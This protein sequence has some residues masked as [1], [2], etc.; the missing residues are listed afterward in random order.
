MTRTALFFFVCKM[1]V[2]E[3]LTSEI[4]VTSDHALSSFISSR[5]TTSYP[6]I[7]SAASQHHAVA[8]LS[9]PKYQTQR[10]TV[11]HQTVRNLFFFYD[12]AAD[13]QPERKTVTSVCIRA[14]IK[15]KKLKGNIWAIGF[16][17]NSEKSIE[18]IFLIYRWKRWQ[19]IRNTEKEMLRNLRVSDKTGVLRDMLLGNR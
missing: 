15:S 6:Q 3:I 19:S 9:K 5:L 18:R 8:V 2:F 1:E 13:S 7:R 11:P 16:K 10:N 17:Y 14:I 4:Q 12:F